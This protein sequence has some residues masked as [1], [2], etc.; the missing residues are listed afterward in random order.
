MIPKIVH[1]CWFGKNPYSKTTNECLKT[2]KK[3]LYD[4]EFILWNEDNSPMN[5]PFVV[6]AYKEKKYAFVADY[7]R[8]WAIYNYGGIYLDTDMY[9]IKEFDNIIL[10]NITLFGFETLKKDVISAGIICATPKNDFI[11][12]ILNKYNSITFD[13]YNIKNI[14]IPKI[15][16]D[17]YTTFENKESITLLAYDFFY[18]FP[19]KNRSEKSFLDYKT[20][21]TYAIHLWEK[22]WFTWND[23]I[24]AKMINTINRIRHCFDNHQFLN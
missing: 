18:P 10:D 9:I 22:S 19:L 11:Y 13:V 4:Y 12:S 24:L 8:L 21:N 3:Y 17:T 2:W 1:Y 23:Y 14:K 6:K 5:H 15:I 7:V 16:T 20:E